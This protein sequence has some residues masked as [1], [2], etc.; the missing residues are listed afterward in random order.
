MEALFRLCGFR[1]SDRKTLIKIVVKNCMQSW[2]YGRLA[3]LVEHLVEAQVAVVQF[4]HRPPTGKNTGERIGYVAGC[5]GMREWFPLLIRQDRNLPWKPD[6]GK[7][8]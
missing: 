5:S 3:Q 6:G 2:L 4:C 7:T 8:R 1:D